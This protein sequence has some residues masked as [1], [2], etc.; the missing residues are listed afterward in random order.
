[1]SADRIEVNAESLRQILSALSGPG[2]LIRE[3]QATIQVDEMLGNK[4][5]LMDLVNEYNAWAK[6]QNAITEAQDGATDG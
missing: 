1:M 3:I 5:P 2:Y 4:N 6:T